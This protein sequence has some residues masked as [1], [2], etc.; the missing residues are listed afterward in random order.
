MKLTQN[1]ETLLFS[2]VFVNH[3]GGSTRSDTAILA[4]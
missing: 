4:G 1:V 3:G 2:F